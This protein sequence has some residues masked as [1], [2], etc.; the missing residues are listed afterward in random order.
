MKILIE[1][2]KANSKNRPDGYVADCLSQGVVNG[3][4]LEIEPSSYRELLNKY[5]P[6]MRGMGDLVEKIARP[7]AHGLDRV[8]GTHI[9]GC[10]GCSKRQD[11]LNKLIPFK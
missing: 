5:R 3:E 10:S 1:A 8:L 9:T 11:V 6:E 2:I 7:I 4:W